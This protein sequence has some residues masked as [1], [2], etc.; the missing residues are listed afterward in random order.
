MYLKLVKTTLENCLSHTLS[1]TN[2]DPREFEPLTTEE[3]KSTEVTLQER[4]TLR[5]KSLSSE[6]T[7]CCVSSQ[8]SVI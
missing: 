1:L 8:I 3:K 7:H 6:I 5:E 2:K 4:E